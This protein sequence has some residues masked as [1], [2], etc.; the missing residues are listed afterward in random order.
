[1]IIL[2]HSAVMARYSP[3]S[4]PWLFHRKPATSWFSKSL[5]SAGY[6]PGTALGTNVVRETYSCPIFFLWLQS[7]HFFF[8]WKFPFIFLRLIFVVCGSFLLVVE[9]W[10]RWGSDRKFRGER[11]FWCTLERLLIPSYWKC[12]KCFLKYLKN[13]MGQSVEI[14]RAEEEW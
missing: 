4:W 11:T 7:W 1:M 14:F 6:V 2:G 10:G 9:E 5:L 3:C 12:Q 13:Y 8:S